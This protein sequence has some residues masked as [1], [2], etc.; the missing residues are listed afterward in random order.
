MK[1]EIPASRRE[2]CQRFV[3]HVGLAGGLVHAVSSTWP[4]ALWGNPK[5]TPKAIFTFGFS[6][7]GM[8]KIPA[9]EAIPLLRQ[10]GFD[11]VELSLLP[12]YD[13]DP[14]QSDRAH[15]QKL[16]S[17]LQH[18][19]VRVTALMEL[20]DLGGDGRTRA[21]ML[22]RLDR[23]CTIAS[24]FA[25][26]IPLVE[27]TMGGGK[28][29]GVK[30]RFRDGLGQWERVAR[31][32]GV[33]LAVKPH[34]FGAVHRPD[35]ALWLV[36]QVNSPWVRLAFDWSHFVH[37]EFLLAEVL[38]ALIPWTAFIH[39]KD[40]VLV[41]GKAVFVL[42]GDSGEVDYGAYFRQL[43]ELGYRGDIC[44]EVSGMVQN[45]P[46]YDPHAAARRCYSNLAPALDLAW[47]SR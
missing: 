19:G 42:P 1:Q 23:A 12:G 41:D 8:K 44:C 26:P 37:R 39:V 33:V 29:E 15:R 16:R 7:Y 2:F 34:R 45:K 9:L 24:E 18:Q 46:Q 3:R 38:R 35:D 17:V 5:P 22:A 20:L 4:S 32:R 30:E 28:W 25:A 40:T 43:V 13:T 47:R 21:N 6:L 36:K 10:I 31:S 11:T 27:T 14:A